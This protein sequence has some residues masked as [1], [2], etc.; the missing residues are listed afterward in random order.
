MKVAIV[1]TGYVGLVSG[2]CLAEMG[3]N[4]MCIDNNEEKIKT[5]ENGDIPIY[6]PGLKEL[7][8]KNRKEG[9]LSF[10]TSVKEG[11]KKCDVIFVAVHTPPLPDGSANLCYVEE[12]SREI[13]E[14]M[15][16]YRIIVSKSTVPVETGKWIKRTVDKYAKEGAEYDVASNPEF[17]REGKAIDDF[18]NPD[19]VVI[20]VE[21]D[22]ARQMMSE[23]YA[24]LKDKTEILITNIES[25]ELIKHA[26]NSF[27][28]MKI[29]Y[30]NAVSN[31]CEKTDADIEEVARGMGLDKRIGNKFLQAGVG[32]GGSCFPK[33]LSAFIKIAEKLGYDFSVLKEVQKINKNQRGLVIEKIRKSL[34]NLNNK[35]IGVLGLAFK[36]D[37]DDMRNAPSIDIIN[38]LVKEGASVKAY[39]PEAAENAKKILPGAITYCEDVY[40]TVKDSDLLLILTDWKQIVEMDMKKVK[41]LLAEPATIVDGR[42]V[43]EPEEMEKLGIKYTSIGR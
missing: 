6:E 23:L 7:V 17:L 42:N 1:G 10:S 34:W 41:E 25:S 13:A 29:S 32:F 36:A 40:E 22:R 35:N 43:F 2:T 5:L 12:V 24:P 30:I 21:S 16:D 4:I 15:D 8:E 9:R 33:D 37:T 26:S 11:V 27:L 14:N 19:R 3:H 28:A 31:I 39:D 20:G 38:Q 18:L